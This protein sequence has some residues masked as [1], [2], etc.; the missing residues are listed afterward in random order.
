[1]LT[2]NRSNLILLLVAHLLLAGLLLGGCLS[3][4]GFLRHL[5]QRPGIPQFNLAGA[6]AALA[7]L[8]L[9]W[10]V[11]LLGRQLWQRRWVGAGAL[12]V[13]LLADGLA[14]GGCV[15]LFFLGRAPIEVYAS[16]EEAQALTLEQLFWLRSK[17]SLDDEEYLV[18][19]RGWKFEKQQTL[20]D[21]TF[22]TFWTFQDSHRKWLADLVYESRG[23]SNL[24][25]LTYSTSNRKT[26]DAIKAQVA[27]SHMKHVGRRTEQGAEWHYF[28]SDGYDVGLTVHS[29]PKAVPTA[30]YIVFVR[31]IEMR[32]YRGTLKWKGGLK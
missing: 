14:L 24:A 21:S 15:L 29:N 4:L 3:Y 19:D 8:L 12:L 1:M 2:F 7:A 18:M 22:S 26:F 16:P 13:L 28:Q 27:A 30:R 5:L 6:G 32:P 31:P 23:H 11:A 10:V 25:S 20:N 17:P 9:A